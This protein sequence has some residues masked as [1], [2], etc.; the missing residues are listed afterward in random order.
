M[1]RGTVVKHAPWL[2]APH[3]AAQD[4]WSSRTASSTVRA[5]RPAAPPRPT[6]AADIFIA[7]DLARMDPMGGVP[8]LP[9][10]KRRVAVEKLPKII[11]LGPPIT[12]PA[13]VRTDYFGARCT[14]PGSSVTRSIWSRSGTAASKLK[15]PSR[16]I[17]RLRDSGRARCARVRPEEDEFVHA[18]LP[19]EGAGDHQGARS[20]W[21]NS[22]L[23]GWLAA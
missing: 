19:S 3:G 15:R 10:L 12:H 7:A 16:T 21:L 22:G 2:R 5:V 20:S 23:P 17:S 6:G 9:V 18:A 4:G 13:I 14:R 11:Q 1:P 8:V